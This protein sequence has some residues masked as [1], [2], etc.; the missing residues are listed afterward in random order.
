MRL[1]ALA[2]VVAAP[3]IA[4][5]DPKLPAHYASLF[6]KGKTFT[7]ELATTGFNY[8]D[9]P[10]GSM[11]AVPTPPEKSAFTCT[12]ADVATF[13][14]GAAAKIT[15][16]RE[17]D[18]DYSFRV[19]GVWVATKAGIARTGDIDL[20]DALPAIDPM[21]AA[22]PKVRR[23]KTKTEFG[24]FLVISTTRPSAGTWCN[25]IDTTKYGAGDGGI[26]TMCFKA[27]AGISR[28]KLDYYGGTPRIVEYKLVK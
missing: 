27:G 22:A 18:S 6:V 12:V 3:S 15:C 19:D 8:I 16:D 26:T 28:G 7:Y 11:Q 5:A 24:G 21:V 10:D 17:I 9:R 2:A 23:V 14:G 25:V 1:L 4:V 13:P 20:P